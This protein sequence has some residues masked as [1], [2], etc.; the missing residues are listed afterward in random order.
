MYSSG[1]D[2]EI[3]A[4]YIKFEMYRFVKIMLL[5]SISYSILMVL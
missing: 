5:D 4:N 2:M 1:R 3:H